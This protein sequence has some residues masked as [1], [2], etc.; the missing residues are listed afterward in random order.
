MRRTRPPR[1]RAFAPTRASRPGAGGLEAIELRAMEARTRA[2]GALGR[3]RAASCEPERAAVL[4]APGVL[5]FREVPLAPLAAGEVRLEVDACGVCGT[6]LHLFRGRPTTDGPLVLGHETVGRVVEAG[7]GVTSLRIGDR[8]ARRALGPGQLRARAP[9]A[10][11]G[12]AR[13]CEALRTWIDRGGGHARFVRAVAS[14]CVRIS[15]ASVRSRRRPCSARATRW[16][17]ALSGRARR[18]ASTL[19][20]SESACGLG[21]PRHPDRPRARCARHRRHSERQQEARCALARCPRRAGDGQARRRA[22]A[23]RVRRRRRGDQ[24]EYDRSGRPRPRPGSGVAVSSSRACAFPAGRYRRRPVGS[25]VVRA[26]SV[27]SVSIGT[28]S[29]GS[30]AWPGTAPYARWSKCTGPRSSERRS[31]GSRTGACAIAR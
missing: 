30:W 24:G 25:R 29:N 6:D 17:A 12:R 15:T 8:V 10:R 18:P 28:S 1:S 13:Y 14:G 7:E 21:H 16:R 23:S 22:R 3:A 2:R 11:A 27:R 4:E 19:P 5:R 31:T 20:S 26:S 9:P